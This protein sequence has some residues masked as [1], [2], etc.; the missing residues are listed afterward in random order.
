MPLW[1]IAL[2]SPRDRLSDFH[3]LE[4]SVH[5][6]KPA[7]LARYTLLVSGAKA[8]KDVAFISSPLL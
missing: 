1:L 8:I 7:I 2:P 3:D 6:Y 4:E 5:D